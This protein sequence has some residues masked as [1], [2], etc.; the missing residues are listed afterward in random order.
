MISVASVKIMD[1]KLKRSHVSTYCSAC[2]AVRREMSKCD[3]EK[4]AHRNI[5]GILT[6]GRTRYRKIGPVV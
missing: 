4:E 3:D 6:H 5:Y 2:L 1:I